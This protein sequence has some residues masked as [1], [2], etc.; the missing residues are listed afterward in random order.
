MNRKNIFKTL[1]AAMLMPAMLLTTSCSS[2]DDALDTPAENTLKKGYTL[3]VTVNVTRQGDDATTRATFNES[4][5]KLEFSAGDKLFVNGTYFVKGSN[6]GVNYVGDYKF[7]GTLDFVS[8]GTFSGNITTQTEWTGTI[9][10]LFEYAYATLLPADYGEYGYL[11]ISGSGYEACLVKNCDKAFDSSKATAVVQFSSESFSWESGSYSNGFALT[12]A[13]AILNFTVN[14]LV[15]STE[16]N[17]E[18]SY[19]HNTDPIVISKSVTTDASG[20]ATFAIGVSYGTD[21]KDCSLTV[22]GNAITLVSESK[23]LEI[24]KIY[25][26]NRSSVITSKLPDGIIGIYTDSKG[27][28][29][30]GIVVTLDNAKYAIETEVETSGTP[31][32][33]VG[34]VDYYTFADAV[35]NFTD[36]SKNGSYGYS[37]ANVWRLPTK[38]EMRALRYLDPHP[39]QDSPAGRIWTIGEAPNQNTL[40]LPAAGYYENDKPWYVGSSGYYWTSSYDEEYASYMNFFQTQCYVSSFNPT[41]GLTVRLFCKLP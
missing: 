13:N 33:S 6:N 35:K 2:E 39:W 21:L 20:T 36:G 34:G 1:A 40:F 31:T 17:M 14:G 3:P 4:T 30:K 37:A 26:I 22:G 7:A 28:A 27:I 10:E 41:Y 25:N 24:G 8:D 11:Y 9:D 15:A 19:P 12:P 23:V 18:F 32:W 16:V 38:T 29:R 5:H